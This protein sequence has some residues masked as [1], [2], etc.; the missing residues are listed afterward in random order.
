MEN[1]KPKR[2][3]EISHGYDRDPSGAGVASP[4]DEER[5]GEY[6]TKHRIRQS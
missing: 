4:Q 2:A 5:K 1:E 6:R 3:G